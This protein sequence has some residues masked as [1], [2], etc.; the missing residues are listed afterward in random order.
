MIVLGFMS[1]LPSKPAHEKAYE[2]PMARAGLNPETAT[3][4]LCND[5]LRR[6]LN[7]RMTLRYDNE[8]GVDA[9]TDDLQPKPQVLAEAEQLISIAMRFQIL[10]EKPL[11][12][13]AMAINEILIERDTNHPLIGESRAQA[14][15]RIQLQHSSDAP[16]RSLQ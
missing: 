11:A 6:A 7:F 15:G 1:H 4:D 16:S 5:V 12:S 3:L 10:G 8:N 13:Y 2:G 14:A 9:H